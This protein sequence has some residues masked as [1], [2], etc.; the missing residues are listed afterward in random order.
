MCTQSF[1][2]RTFLGAASGMLAAGYAAPYGA[3]S[4]SFARQAKNDRFVLGAIG[5]G[6]QGTGIAGRATKFGD[7]VAVCDVDR[8]HAERAREKFGG[9][10]EICGDYR[11]LL[12]RKDIDAAVTIGTPD[13]WHTAVALAALRAGKD[14]YCEKPLTLTIDGC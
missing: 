4:R 10:A 8:Q 14:V 1:T 5:V 12:E 3:A 6:G 7:I 9:K 2:R 11:K 13:H